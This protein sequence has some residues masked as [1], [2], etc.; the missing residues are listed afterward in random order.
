[1]ASTLHHQTIKH[2]LTAARMSTYEAATAATPQLAGALALYAWNA[3]VSAA[4]MAPLHI[5]E[6]VIRN[7]VADALA[8]VYG[9]D[10][11]WQQVFITSL[12]NPTRG[13]NPRADILNVR[14]GQPTTGKVIPELKFVFW[15][16]LFTRRF[17]DRIWQPHMRAVMPCLDPAK[18]IAQLRGSIYGELDQLRRLRNRIAH[19]EPIFTRHLA[20]DFQKIQQLIAL[21]CPITSAWMTEN[22]QAA[23][24]IAHKPRMA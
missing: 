21:R 18:T 15:Q 20:D 5:C 12:P 11:P 13:Y 8:A 6:V 9:P 23:E 2:A 16:T 4:L 10:W 7:A 14:A 22:Q 19:H 17:D 3:Q 24:L 1:M